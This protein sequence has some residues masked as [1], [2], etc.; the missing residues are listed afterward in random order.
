[1]EKR[2]KILSHR[3]KNWYGANTG[4]WRVWASFL[5]S[6]RQH[7]MSNM[8][9][10]MKINHGNIL[11]SLERRRQRFSA[12][13]SE[14]GKILPIILAPLDLWSIFP[15]AISAF[16]PLVRMKT[17]GQGISIWLTPLAWWLDLVSC[18]FFV[19]SLFSTWSDFAWLNLISGW[20]ILA[21]RNGLD[22]SRSRL[23]NL[24]IPSSKLRRLAMP[25]APMGWRFP[26]FVLHCL[27]LIADIAVCLHHSSSLPSILWMFRA[28]IKCSWPG[29]LCALWDL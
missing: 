4:N 12:S 9:I 17:N 10:C 27:Q 11:L 28:R 21:Q 6:E 23:S 18:S 7:V 29:P 24:I 8:L 2:K 16:L 1:M 19:A 20:S 22:C 13:K 15:T 3:D 5:W 25:R 14:L 26:R